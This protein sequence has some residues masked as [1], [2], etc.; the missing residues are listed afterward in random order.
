MGSLA[1][2]SRLRLRLSCDAPVL[3][4]ESVA[5]AR[6]GDLRTLSG[7]VLR[8]GAATHRA[9][10]A[11][12]HLC[13]AAKVRSAP[14]PRRRA[15]AAPPRCCALSPKNCAVANCALPAD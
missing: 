3:A 12:M 5:P 2:S 4:G 14:P 10:D 15:A 9:L 7:A 8:A 13:K 6:G 1:V 11:V